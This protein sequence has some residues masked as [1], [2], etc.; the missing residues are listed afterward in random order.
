MKASIGNNWSTLEDLGHYDQDELGRPS[1]I[2]WVQG[3]LILSWLEAYDA[4]IHDKLLI[5]EICGA[6]LSV[7]EFLTKMATPNGATMEGPRGPKLGMSNVTKFL[8]LRTLV[9]VSQGTVGINHV[10][11]DTSNKSAVD[12]IFKG[13]LFFNTKDMVIFNQQRVIPLKVS[14]G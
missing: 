3:P 9:L 2:E 1:K 12:A 4:L 5:H 7:T 11:R 6:I 13:M 8:M 10:Q 14:Q